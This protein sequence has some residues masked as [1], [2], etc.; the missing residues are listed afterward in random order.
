MKICIG[1]DHR[2]QQYREMIKEALRQRGHVVEDVG[3]SCSGPA[4]YP[5]Y[6]G[7]VAGAV[8]DGSADRGILI[9]SSGIGMSMAANRYTGI[10]AALCFTP[11]MAETSR[12]HN[13][14]NVLCLGQD[15]VDESKVMAILDAWLDTEFEG[16][17]HE[18]RLEKLD[19]NCRA[20]R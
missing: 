20:Q 18:K 15:T 7:P 1:S 6:A 8:R 4:D 13:D 2:G 16:G 12:R 19:L 17:R 9:C 3:F 5:D 14:A 10:R 11:Q